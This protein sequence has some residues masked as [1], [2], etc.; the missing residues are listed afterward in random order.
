MT[1]TTPSN[2]RPS[3]AFARVAT[4]AG[5]TAVGLA[6]VG[7]WPTWR[8]AGGEGLSGMAFGIG[9]ALVGA[10]AGSAPTCLYLRK[11]PIE[12]PTGIMLGLGVRFAV[13]VGL[14]LAVWLHGTF[15]SKALPLWVGIAQ[16]VILAVDV[17]G[18]VNL[19][20]RVAKEGA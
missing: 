4:L 18:L 2:L 13:T 16:F 19:L 5:L 11:P 9:I 10:W 15:E 1:L 12:H 14:L 3:I 7:A 8:L 6:L 17:T 20:K